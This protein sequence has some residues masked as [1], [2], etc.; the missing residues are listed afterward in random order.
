MKIVVLD[1]SC[2]M[3]NDLNFDSFKAFGDLTVYPR[4]AKCDVQKRIGDAEAVFLNKVIIDDAIMAACPKLKFIGILATGYNVVDI[5]AAEKH[6]ITVCNVPAYST[7]SVAQ[8][9]FALIL[10]LAVH[11][12]E[13]SD[14]VA[15]GDWIRYPDFC[16]CVTPLMEL[17]GKT[18]GLIGYGNIGKAVE[19][20][21]KAF[22]MKVL[23]NNRT[24]FDGSVTAE[25]VFAKSDI[26]SL[27]CPL[28]AANKELINKKTLSMMKPT[29][30][31]INTARG[32]LINEADLAEALNGG[33]IAGA[34]L[35]V[36]SAEPPSD[37]NPLIGAKNCVI[38]PHTAWATS[39]AR[40]RLLEVARENLK[41]FIS[42]KPKNIIKP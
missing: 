19:R 38:T 18:L 25:E 9:T 37:G 42:G 31:L 35:D 5:L 12:G 20:I 6:G 22:N 23:V 1:G 13:H 16:Y 26:I 2:L 10:E 7:D 39:E 4:T 8:Q 32:G 34:G 36:L 21:A 29:A 30:F 33:R 11:V 3:Q 41:A 40:G 28:N 14:T 24:P 27:H 15:E 17:S